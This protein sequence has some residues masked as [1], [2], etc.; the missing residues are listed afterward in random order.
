[1]SLRN[2]KL[3]C[4][5]LATLPLL[6][7]NF[8]EINGIVTD[9]SGGVMVGAN[10]T[11]TNRATNTA[12]TVQTNSSG[13]YTLPFL[14]PGLYDIQVGQT[15]FRAVRREGVQLE[16][17]AAA[18]VD[19]AMEVGS[20][21][22]VVAVTASAALLTTE[23][24]A[25]GTVIENKRIVELP[26]NGRDY[27]QLIALSP[28]VT[29]ETPPSFTATGR[30]G[31]ERANQNYSIAG[32]RLQFTHYTLDGIE[33]TDPNWNLWIFRPSI[34]ALQE[35]KVETGVYSAEYGHQPSQVNVTTKSGT[36]EFH[37][38]AFEFLRNSALDAR[39]WQQ[40]SG[41]KNPF[42]RNQYGFVLG[43]P[44]TIPKLFSG[45]DRLFFMSNFEGLR[46]SNTLQQVASVATDRMRAGDFSAS[47]RTIYDPD[48]RVFT[49]DANGN[50][51]AVSATPFA[52]NVIP[53]SQFSPI[54]VKL[55]EFYPAPTTPGDQILRNYTR[56]AH[57]PTN[58]DQFTHRIDFNERNKSFWFG[59]FGWN[60]EFTSTASLFPNQNEQYALTA[61]QVMVS[62]IRT[63]SP[64]VTNEFRFGFNQLVSNATTSSAYSRN[65]TA[66]LGM[67]GIS[68]TSPAAWGIPSLTLGNGLTGFGDPVDAPFLDHNNTFQWMDNA[69]VTRGSHSLRFGGEIRRMRVNEQ[70]N[71]YNR[72]NMSFT[73]S[74]TFDPA[75][76]LNTGYSFADFLLG[77]LNGFNWAGALASVQ[78]RSTPASLYFEDVWKI[79]PKLTINSGLR[80]ELYPPYHDKYR[81]IMNAY[82]FD[83]GVGPNGKLATTR[84]P[85][86]VRPGDGPF[87]EGAAAHFIDAIPTA[88]GADLEK[89]GL[90]S[91]TIKADRNDFAPRLGLA[92]NAGAWTLRTGLGI[93]FAHDVS[94][95][96]QSATDENLAGRA[97][98]NASVE[99][100]NAPL[101]NPLLPTTGQGSCT[102]WTGICQGPQTR[103]YIVDPNL[104]TPYIVQWLFNVQRQLSQGVVLEA[105]YQGNEGHKLEIFRNYNEPVL[106]SGPSDASSLQQRRPWANFGQ[107]QSVNG[108]V[109]SNYHALTTKLSQRLSRG[110]TSMVSFTWSKAI[111]NGS[112][113]RPSLLTNGSPLNWYDFTS[114]RG[115]SDF[116]VGRRFVA[117][118]LY[119]LPFGKGNLG[120]INKLTG[121]WQLGGILTIADGTPINVG[122]IGDVTNTEN[123]SLP[124]ATGI[125]PVPAEQTAQ[126]FWNIAAFNTTDPA[127]NFRYG[128]TARNVLF[129]PG[130]VNWDFSAI[131]NTPIMER[132]SLQFRFEAY[133][134]ANHPNW[135]PPS[136][137]V[138]SPATFGVVTS[139][140]PMRVMQVALKYSF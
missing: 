126:H 24:A 75:S 68:N 55:L 48:S 40:S 98:V 64:T 134:F 118:V 76:R 113:L 4:G 128:N 45:R 9:P 127:L 2:L 138:L 52:N 60:D 44:V 122:G 101:S 92:Y 53:R 7:Q 56:Q 85:V 135:L 38:S 90:P 67:A 115:L 89:L 19:V 14:T 87:Y 74:A 23:G 36:N 133:N 123:S 46:D 116:N 62:N 104:R 42:R 12:R 106:R 43:G 130:T 109:N 34:D 72:T 97:N 88:T 35:F 50:V 66:E 132:Q 129:T 96:T 51:K 120:V 69:S 11:A 65:V 30:Q 114:N 81:S 73:G 100:P 58:W 63:F 125:S 95:A 112:A 49:T 15:G 26:L 107:L 117:S 6:A 84:Q 16:V 121:G 18:R 105:G 140:K 28:A 47:G 20:V 86:L 77:R 8:G 61:Y 103:I 57:T 91:A 137:A 17:G 124:D 82:L 21:S 111:D 79:T 39:Q 70:G 22:D 13:N 110:L 102:R 136:N 99:Q 78:F 33:N 1:M 41:P 37:G 5:V 131:K 71:I 29:A 31:G 59:R 108:V 10:V 80:Y 32:Q 83:P 94:N 3:L 27:L 54:A 93:F 139:A 25:V 119:E